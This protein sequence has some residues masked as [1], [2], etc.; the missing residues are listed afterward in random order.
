MG[1]VKH[2][3]SF[4]IFSQISEADLGVQGVRT[5][6]L[7]LQKRKKYTVSMLTDNLS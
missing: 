4:F 6:C 7:N 1:F 5:P 2:M 3:H